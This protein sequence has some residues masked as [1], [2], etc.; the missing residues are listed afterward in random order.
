MP[1][2]IGIL[3]VLLKGLVVRKRFLT[4]TTIRHGHGVT[5]VRS[6]SGTT[7]GVGLDPELIGLIWVG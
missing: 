6:E 1:V 7:G 5:V 4:A 3:F 2:G